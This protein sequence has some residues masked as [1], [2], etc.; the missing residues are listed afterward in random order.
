MMTFK[1]LVAVG[2]AATLFASCS[3][4]ND[5][6]ENGG[7]TNPDVFGIGVNSQTDA[8]ILSN[9]VYNFKTT[10][11]RVAIPTEYTNIANLSMSEQPSIP[12]NAVDLATYK[13]RMWE[14]PT[15]KVYVLKAGETLDNANFNLEGS[16]FYIAGTLKFQNYGWGGNAK[17]YI[18]NGGTLELANIPNNVDFYNY[19]TLNIKT[20]DINIGNGASLY[21]YGSMDVAG[22]NIKV[23]VNSNIYVGGSLK[24]NTLF[25]NNG[26]KARVINNIELAG[27]LTNI[28]ELYVGGD[29]KIANFDG[30]N[31]NTKTDIKGQLD[32]SNTDVTLDGFIHVGGAIKAKSLYTKNTCNLYADCSVDVEGLYK[33]DSS[34]AGLHVGNIH[35]GSIEHCSGA[36]I[37][38][39]NGGIIRCDGEYN[40]QNS[41]SS[42]IVLQDAGAKAVFKAGSMK[43]NDGDKAGIFSTPNKG[44]RS[45]FY[46]DCPTYYKWNGTAIDFDDV[47]WSGNAEQATADNVVINNNSCN[48]GGYNDPGDTPT[49]PTPP[50]PSKP[51][52][53]VIGEIDYDHTHD[54]SATCVQPYN[55]KLY[56][57]YHTRGN[58]QGGCLEVFKVE[59][60][61][62]SL[63]QFLRDKNEELDFNHCMVDAQVS[64]ARLYAVGNSKSKGAM[65]SYININN[66][67]LLNAT[68]SVVIEGTDENN[69]KTFQPLNV[70]PL[71][72]NDKTS[73]ADENCIVRDGDRLLV[74][75]TRGFEIYD[76]NNLNMLSSVKKDGKSKHITL[77]G[78]KI[79]TL[80]LD[81]QASKGSEAIPA[82]I[83][84]FSLGSDMTAANK[85][86]AAG[87]IQPNN[88]KNTIAVDGEN[89]YACL[90]GNGF[91]CYKN[92]TLA[93]T[94]KTPLLNN[95]QPRGY[96]NGVAFN[97]K[98]IFLAYGSYGVVVIDKA[99][100]TADNVNIVARLKGTNNK[101]ANYIAVDD[102]YIYV[103]YGKERMRVYKFK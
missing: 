11:T 32:L 16:T 63:L 23:D 102:N 51:G 83:E 52:F 30:T 76:A 71:D 48:G 54:I 22:K 87:I 80:T 67:G 34:P 5:V 78:G 66:D 82:T 62:V 72:A 85:K 68:D 55:G 69:H 45:V 7:I 4:S 56:M 43:W 61:Q 38:L 13:D 81:R 18:L 88:G 57:T 2:L 70:V 77:Q 84:E 9:R 35:A 101:S 8:N 73:N 39:D 33:I 40:N 19:G 64:P 10:S 74:T 53:D 79:T 60:D 27:T 100:T 75:S 31:S 98:Y 21:N 59:N 86:W 26:A 36:T 17:F 65:L 41:N 58:E 91:A 95:G 103:A 29:C 42:L 25:V 49:P 3:D 24:A 46:V 90:S 15:G 99:T 14:V 1:T 44:D 94:Y 93:W 89:T 97:D 12:A 37:Y 47:T 92:G 28:S 50:T 6:A 96:C 20:N